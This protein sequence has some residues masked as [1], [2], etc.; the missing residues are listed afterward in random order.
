[1]HWGDRFLKGLGT[2]V[3]TQPAYDPLSKQPELKASAIQISKV[4]LPWEFFALVE[5]DIQAHF[6][7]L[8]P[9]VGWF[10]LRQL[11]PHRA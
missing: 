6:N 1:M 8:A 2:N 5:G 9:A 4:V 10:H 7:R 3:L 11:Q